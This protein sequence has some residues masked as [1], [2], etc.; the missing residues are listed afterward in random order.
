MRR[1]CLTLPTDRPCVPAL[2][3]VVREAAHGAR[4]F[5]VEV[6]VLVLDSA[7]AAA[8]AEHRAAIGRL[9]P[10]PGVVVHHFDEEEQRRL[11]RDLATAAAPGPADRL[12]DL[13]LPDAVSYGACTDRA[14]LIAEALGCASVHRRDS[15][16][17]YQEH[18]GET[19]HPIHQELAFLD[20]TASDAAARVS[21][22]RLRPDAQNRQVVLVGGSFIGDMS[23]DLDAIRRLDP[24]AYERVIALTVPDDYPALWR[25]TLV[26]DS[27]RGGGTTPFTGDRTTLTSVPPTRVDMCNIALS[28]AVYARVPLP[29]ATDTVGS[30]YFLLHVVHAAGLPGVQHNRHIVNHHTPD[31][32]TDPAFLA[33]QT[34]LAKYFLAV[35]RLHEIHTAL[36]A[37]GTGLL[38]GDGLLR[39]AA[40]ADP[41]RRSAADARPGDAHRLDVLDSVYRGLGGRWAE[42]ADLLATRRNQLLAEARADMADFAF[43]LDAWPALIDAARTR[44]LVSAR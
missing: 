2:G 20:T 5:G 12:L 44:G 34:R 8:Q 26:A 32:R 33:Y 30:D 9:A 1:V 7:P 31:R 41:V 36:G 18:A 38:D 14:F 27:F 40:V 15:D 39:T 42:A 43:L 25:S 4:A 10:A 21:A 17:G 37:T 19:V 3:D 16:S 13:L 28:R 29:P 6:H 24:A 11:L 23:V 35:P 22:R